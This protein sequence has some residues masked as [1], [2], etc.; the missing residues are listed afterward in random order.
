MRANVNL[1]QFIKFNTVIHSD[2]TW[3]IGWPAAVAPLLLVKL[4]RHKAHNFCASNQ[5]PRHLASDRGLTSFHPSISVTYFCIRS[6]AASPA[7]VRQLLVQGCALLLKPINSWRRSG[8]LNL[9]GP[10]GSNFSIIIVISSIN[11]CERT[12][13]VRRKV[14]I[15]HP[16]TILRS[17]HV[18]FVVGRYVRNVDRQSRWSPSKLR[19]T[20][21][22]SADQRLLRLFLIKVFCCQFFFLH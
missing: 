2:R 22:G 11:S 8:L 19:P 14:V 20:L 4:R 1:F 16:M 17:N 13:K 9:L 10:V 3:H 21:T 18:S 5:I 12:R 7:K 15:R 6:S